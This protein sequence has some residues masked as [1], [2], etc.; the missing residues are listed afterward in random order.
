VIFTA[1]RHRQEKQMAKNGRTQH[2]NYVKEVVHVTKVSFNDNGYFKLNHGRVIRVDLKAPWDY[3]RG[4]LCP[5]ILHLAPCSPPEII[6]DLMAHDTKEKLR[7]IHT[8]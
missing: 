3:L 4:E 8:C 1:V 7:F 5:A 2:D 6:L